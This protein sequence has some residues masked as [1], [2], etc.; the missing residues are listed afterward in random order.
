MEKLSQN[1][2]CEKHSKIN[3]KM[4]QITTTL[5]WQ[6]NREIYILVCFFVLY[7]AHILKILSNY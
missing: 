5:K 1:G 7:I 2:V 6:K 3:R 4:S